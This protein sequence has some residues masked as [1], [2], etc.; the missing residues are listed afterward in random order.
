MDKNY[1]IYS[2]ITERTNGDVYIGVVGPV[3]CGKSTFIQKFMQNFVLENITN[4]H[5]K[6]RATDELPAACDGAMVMTTK[7]QFVPAQAVK[8]KIGNASM[9]VKLIDSVGYMVEGAMGAYDGNAP[10]LV[11]T[12]WSAEEIPFAQ[13]AALGTEKVISNH[14]TIAVV[15]T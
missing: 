7:P 15:M 8:V 9:S 3:R 13:A 5:D 10:R 11:K 4:K 6:E 14:S 2:D 12:P 1:S